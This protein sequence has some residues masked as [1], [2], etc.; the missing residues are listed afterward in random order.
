MYLID[1]IYFRIDFLKMVID[2]MGFVKKFFKVE[3]IDVIEL[4]KFLLIYG[5]VIV[6]VLIMV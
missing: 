6:I 1:I 4:N 3:I 2:W 5:S